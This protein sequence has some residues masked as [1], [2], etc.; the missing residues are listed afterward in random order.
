MARGPV[1]EGFS[2][3]VTLELRFEG[4]HFVSRWRVVLARTFAVTFPPPT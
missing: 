2:A 3:E 1:R 4:S